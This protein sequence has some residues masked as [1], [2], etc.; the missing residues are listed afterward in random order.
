[1]ILFFFHFTNDG[2]PY[3]IIKTFRNK[4]VLLSTVIYKTS[5]IKGHKYK[6]R[7]YSLEIHLLEHYLYLW[8]VNMPVGKA[9]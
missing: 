2:D 4:S 5:Q 9:W 6:I 1:M 7:G 8:Y 3:S